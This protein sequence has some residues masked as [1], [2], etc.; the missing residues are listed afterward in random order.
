M[1]KRGRKWGYEEYV[2]SLLESTDNQKGTRIVTYD[3]RGR[4]TGEIPSAFYH[5]IKRG[6]A[7]GLKIKRIEGSVYLTSEAGAKFLVRLVKDYNKGA[8]SKVYQVK[9][10][11]SVD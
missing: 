10:T 11:T 8:E 5:D 7:R 3:F 2:K 4:T 6:L 1:G 9:E